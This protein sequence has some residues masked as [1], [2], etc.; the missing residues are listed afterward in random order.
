MELQVYRDSHKNCKSEHNRQYRLDH[1]GELKRKNSAYREQNREQ[2]NQND[3]DRYWLDPSK[4][5]QKCKLYR[6]QHLEEMKAHDKDY[7]QKNKD[8]L[9]PKK[10]AY[11]MQPSRRDL[12][13]RKVYGITLEF[14]NQM[15]DSQEGKCAICGK[16]LERIRGVHI[17]H[18]HSTGI[19]RALLCGP[20]NTGLGM[21]KDNPQILRQAIE[22]LEQK[23]G[24]RIE[25]QRPGD[26]P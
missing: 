11:H 24:I 5:A 4:S 10:R 22:Y 20:C 2:L 25:Q 23:S 19:V 21:F 26:C 8:T 3:R 9:L 6:E 12:R 16:S 13:L 17:D 1:L 14:F 18:D 7:Y 15:F